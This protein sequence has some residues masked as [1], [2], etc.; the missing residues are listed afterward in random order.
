MNLA[1]CQDCFTSLEQYDD[2]QK[3]S[4][5]IEVKLTNLFHRDRAVAVFIK[6]E[7]ISDDNDNQTIADADFCDVKDFA[8]NSSESNLE[9]EVFGKLFICDHCGAEHLNQKQFLLH[10]KE[11]ISKSEQHRCE[12]CAKTFKTV[13]SL[14]FH[15]AIDHDNAGAPLDCP[16]CFKSHENRSSL[17]NHY[18]GHVE[19]QKNYLCFR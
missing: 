15:V 19:T 17:R 10:V 4:K 7:N 13:A 14:S 2:L 5:E 3:Q 12:A 11:H 6:Q 1:V 8:E 16:I 9:P 18:Y